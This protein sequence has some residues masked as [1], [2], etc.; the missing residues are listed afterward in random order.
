M[1][2][3]TAQ[4]GF[5]RYYHNTASVTGET[6]D[7]ALEE[8]RKATGMDDGWRD[9]GH[10]GE[11]FVE[12]VSEGEGTDPW[13]DSLPI[14][15]GFSEHGRAFERL[16]LFELHTPETGRRRYFGNQPDA[17]RAMSTTLGHSELSE[18]ALYVAA[19][20]PIDDEPTRAA[21]AGRLVA[22]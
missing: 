5:A 2:T 21:Q 18:I 12:A 20:T 3:Y 15:L 1:K 19:R 14:P 6:L 11:I 8:A 7:A 10:N 22:E 13:A 16:T 9:F 4:C 17:L